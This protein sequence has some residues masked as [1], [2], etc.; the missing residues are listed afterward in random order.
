[1]GYI[2]ERLCIAQG[3]CGF[4]QPCAFAFPDIG[5]MKP[6]MKMVWESRKNI[7]E[8]ETALETDFRASGKA[9]LQLQYVRQKR[10]DR[11]PAGLSTCFSSGGRYP[12]AHQGGQQ[13]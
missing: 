6:L 7:L 2:P 11:Y 12:Q 1:M 3:W 13:P 9:H 5:I 10:D 4:R 8:F